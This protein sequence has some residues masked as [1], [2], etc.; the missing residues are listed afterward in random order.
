MKYF[1][2]FITCIFL[3]SSCEKKTVEI[4]EKIPTLKKVTYTQTYPSGINLSNH[5]FHYNQSTGRLE[6][7]IYNYESIKNSTSTLIWI[8]TYIFEY[9]SNAQVNKALITYDYR[10]SSTSHTSTVDFKYDADRISGYHLIENYPYG[11]T[12]LRVSYQYDDKGN[13]NKSYI[14]NGYT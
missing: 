14:D 1:A 9:N 7:I 8:I 4:K 13:I 5:D 12:S 11:A 10:N 3:F 2:I 6:K